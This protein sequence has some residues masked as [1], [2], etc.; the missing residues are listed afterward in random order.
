MGPH[1][2][3]TSGGLKNGH[4]NHRCAREGALRAQGEPLFLLRFSDMGSVGLYFFDCP[5]G[6]HSL[7]M[8]QYCGSGLLHPCVFLGDRTVCRNTDMCCLC[9]G[10]RDLELRVECEG[11]RQR[12]WGLKDSLRTHLNPQSH[13]S[14]STFAEG[15]LGQP[16]D[17]GYWTG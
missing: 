15:K 10:Y 2:L 8:W 5:G 4:S 13:C 12:K 6:H 16:R 7:H 9:C 3:P 1:P 11:R 14:V 17:L